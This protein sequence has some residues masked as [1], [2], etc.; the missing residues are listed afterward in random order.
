MRLTGGAS[1]EKERIG[2]RRAAAAQGQGPQPV[3]HQSLAIFVLQTPEETSVLVEG[4]DPAVAEV[5][6][7]DVAAESAEGIGRACDAPRRIERPAADQASQQMS[8]GIE[9]IDKAAAGTGRIVVLV[10]FLFRISDEEIATEVRYAEGRVA[11]R[12][13]RVLEI[14]IGRC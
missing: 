6:H 7:E 10:R 8:V 11:G 1:R 12:D 5:A 4:V 9:H 14:A 3:Y 2:F 13:P